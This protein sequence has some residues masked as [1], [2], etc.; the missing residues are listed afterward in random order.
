M[1]FGIMAFLLTIQI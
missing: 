1:Y